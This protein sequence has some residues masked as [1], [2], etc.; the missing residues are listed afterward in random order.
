MLKIL[1]FIRHNAIALVA[2]FV[3]I[4]GSSYAAVSIN[5]SQIRNG[6]INAVKLDPT[7]IAGSIRAWA[8]IYGD[9]TSVTAGPSSSHIRVSTYGVGESITWTHRRFAQSC[10]PMATPLGSPTTGGYGSVTTQFDA[11]DGTLT[12]QGFGPDKVGRPQPA[13]VM[14]VCP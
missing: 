10:M 6:T 4:G 5:G 2:L 8:I 1:T 7:S 14:I 3:A 12:L 13:Y 9:S 11:R